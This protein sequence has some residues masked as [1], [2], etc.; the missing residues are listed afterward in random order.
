VRVQELPGQEHDAM[1]TAPDIY[2]SET[3]RNVRP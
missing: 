2:A 3:L 1:L